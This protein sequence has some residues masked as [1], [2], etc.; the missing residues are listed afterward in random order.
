MLGLGSWHNQNEF[1]IPAGP[2][3]AAIDA[4]GYQGYC[5][6]AGSIIAHTDLG[7]AV[8]HLD[9]GAGKWNQSTKLTFESVR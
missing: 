7:D 2:A 4:K 5:K 6:D 3:I 1:T 9:A 8:G